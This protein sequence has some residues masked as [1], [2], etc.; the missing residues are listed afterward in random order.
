MGGVFLLIVVILYLLF[1]IVFINSININSHDFQVARS[2]FERMIH[3]CCQIYAHPHA[4]QAIK[5]MKEHGHHPGIVRG[6]KKGRGK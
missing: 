6:K 2:L 5:D 4:I 3:V 1:V